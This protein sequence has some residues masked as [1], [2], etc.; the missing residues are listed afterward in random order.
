MED[1]ELKFTKRTKWILLLLLINVLILSACSANQNTPYKTEITGAIDTAPAGLFNPIFYMDMYEETILELTHE[2]LVK[3]NEQLEFEPNLA[4][5]WTVNED[6]TSITFNLEEDVKWHDGKPFTA[7]DV[8][9]TYQTMS[10][11]DYVAA[12]G[13][14]TLFVEP[15]LGYQDYNNGD[16]TDFIGVVAEDDYTVTFHFTEPS[17]TPLYMASVPIIP[18]HV[19]EDIPIK[20]MPGAPASQE[21]ES[22]IGTGPYK[23]VHITDR[24][25]YIF[26]RHEDYWQGTPEIERLNYRVVESSVMIGLIEKGEI[27]FVGRPSGINSAD[28]NTL[29]ENNNLQTIEQLDFSY[30]VLGFKLNHRTNADVE[31][32]AIEPNNWVENDKLSNPKVRRAIAYAL[33]R[34]GMV[35]GLLYG[36]GAVIN[37]PI[38]PQHWAS[39]EERT[40]QYAFDSEQAKI[41]LD[42]AG[43]KDIDGDGFRE[44]PDGKPWRL[45]MKYP[46]G[47]ELRER[48]A[49]LIKQQLEDVGISVNLKQ[50]K[51]MSAFLIDMENDNE[52]DDTDLYLIGWGLETSDPDPTELWSSYTPWNYSRWHN[53][54]SDEFIQKAISAP[55]GLDQDNRA[56]IYA[57][58]QELFSEDLPAVL[59]YIEPALWIYNKRIDGVSP[60]PHTLFNDIHKW[61]VDVE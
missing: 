52:Q 32:N 41:L 2:R 35:N 58:W 9:F 29:A 26:L 61:S 42:E 51:E 5:N 54:S 7:H 20:D 8:V 46:A 28:F 48:T 34:E 14:R 50:P 12:G 57:S 40:K 56:E 22:I 21:A 30:Q 10:D 37:S 17:I 11:P 47:N 38:A 24:E 39:S 1:V 55:D 16:T 18:K 33:N 4:K 27:D 6:H 13:L 45:N 15:L 36:K 44:T 59:L 25:R 43:Y 60:L 31:N 23:F 53:E 3:Q 49:P 19:F